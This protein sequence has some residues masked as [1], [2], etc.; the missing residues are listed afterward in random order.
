MIGSALAVVAMLGVWSVFGSFALAIGLAIS[1]P[2]AGTLASSFGLALPWMLPRDRINP[3]FGAEPV[4]TITQD[5]LTIPIYFM[6]MTA[7]FE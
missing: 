1:L 6:V 2:L 5:V 4:A 3:A 7:L